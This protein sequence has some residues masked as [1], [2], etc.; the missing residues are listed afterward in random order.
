MKNIRILVEDRQ[1]F[2]MTQR[3]EFL[4]TRGDKKNDHDSE[5]SVLCQIEVCGKLSE[6]VEHYFAGRTTTSWFW[7]AVWWPLASNIFQFS[8][9]VLFCFP[10][11]LVYLNGSLLIWA[12]RGSSPAAYKA[13]L[14]GDSITGRQ[15]LTDNIKHVEDVVVDTDQSRILWT[16][17]ELQTVE[18]VDLD[19]SNQKVLPSRPLQYAR[20]SE[21]AKLQSH[22]RTFITGYV[23][24]VQVLP[25]QAVH[26]L[27]ELTFPKNIDVPKFKL[28]CS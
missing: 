20:V 11:F 21:N 10:S 19:G 15:L 2:Q 26:I 7:D 25:N 18:A 22:A 27:L 28:T 13:T 3:Q 16:D 17:S 24:V 14:T 23:L 12:E 9:S 5:S 1:K 4:W 8:P 6:Q